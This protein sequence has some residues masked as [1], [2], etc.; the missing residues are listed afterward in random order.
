MPMPKGLPSSLQ[1]H[2]RC[3][4]SVF[5]PRTSHHLSGRTDALAELE[6][7]LEAADATGT[8][9]TSMTV[10]TPLQFLVRRGELA[11]AEGTLATWHARGRPEQCGLPHVAQAEALVLEAREETDRA[12]A[13]VRRVWT[14]AVDGGRVV[15][16]LLADPTRCASLAPQATMV[17]PHVSPGTPPRYH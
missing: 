3:A 11:A 7:A 10:A 6:S 4:R 17:S 13:L 16:P 1:Q 8:G 15:W 2:G 14:R 5:Y 9:W 12:A